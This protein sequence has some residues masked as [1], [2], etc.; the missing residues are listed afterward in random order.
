MYVYNGRI[1]LGDVMDIM[2]QE[3]GRRIALRRKR[4]KLNQEELAAILDVSNNH[5]SSIERGHSAPSIDL[6]VKIC[7][8][9]KVTPDYLLLGSMHSNNISQNIMDSLRLCSDKQIAFVY[10]IVQLML[11]EQFSCSDSDND[12]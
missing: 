4:L 2:H 7:T 1:S 5:I 9:L 8:T 3:L 10:Q 12:K 6:F 11:T